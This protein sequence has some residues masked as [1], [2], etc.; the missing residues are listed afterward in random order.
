MPRKLYEENA[1]LTEFSATVLSCEAVTGGYAAVLDQ[2]AFF[3]EEGGQGADHGSLASARVLDAS[4]REGVITHLIDAPLPVGAVVDGHIDWARRHRHMQHHTGEHILS[5]TLHRLYGVRNVGFHLYHEVTL[6]TDIPLNEEQLH[7]AETEANEAVFANRRVIAEY[8]AA[9]RLKDM[10]Y[11]AKLALTE[12]VRVVSIEGVDACACCAPHLSSTGEVGL[13]K[14]VDFMHYKGG[15]RLFIKCG[16]DAL[17][18]YR[19][20]EAIIQSLVRR[21]SAKGDKLPEALLRHFEEFEAKKA[22]IASLENSLREA[23]LASL[24]KTEGILPLFYPALSMNQLRKY[25]EE[26]AAFCDIAA[27]FT[28]EGEGYRYCLTSRSTDVRPLDARLH[29]SLGG[30]GGGKAQST[31]GSLPATEEAIKNVLFDA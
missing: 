28:P 25:A 21:F 8:P 19:E 15:M 5:G 4:I 14:I 1:Y 20:K 9:E 6:D 10:T 22:E 24:R 7:L 30:K 27:L 12:G 3:P 29:Q 13:I 16:A 11:R 31:A 23:R 26:A 17:A 18:D 2:T